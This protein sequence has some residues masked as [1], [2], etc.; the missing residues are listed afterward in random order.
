ME[1]QLLN[2]RKKFILNIIYR[3]PHGNF[4][5]FLQKIEGL[6]LES[7]IKET[8]VIYLGDFN[9]LVEDAQKFLRLL[10]NFFLNK[11][12]N[13][14]TYNSGHTLDLVITKSRHFLV[15]SLTVDTINIFFLIMGMLISI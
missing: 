8:N 9:I 2:K 15:K 6:I 4:A 1:I 7:E 13:K 10:D 12:V 5:L 11:L 3:Q 14:P